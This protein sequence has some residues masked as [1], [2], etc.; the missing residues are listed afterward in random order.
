M[1]RSD[2]LGWFDNSEAKNLALL[3]NALQFDIIEDVLHSDILSR[4]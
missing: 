3:F 1:E 4:C 2:Y